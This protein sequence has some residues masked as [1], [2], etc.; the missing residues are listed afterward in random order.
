MLKLIAAIKSVFSFGLVGTLLG[1]LVSYALEYWG[2]HIQVFQSLLDE[3]ARPIALP[4]VSGNVFLAF[5]FA[6]PAALLAGLFLGGV[7]LFI[8]RWSVRPNLIS[9]LLLGASAGFL[10]AFILYG[11]QFPLSWPI[12][13]SLISGALAAL[14]LARPLEAWLCPTHHTSALASLAA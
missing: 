4:L 6:L 2:S 1:A 14:L 13:S 7:V 12:A 3:Q 10:A 5:G 11:S 8:A 9:W